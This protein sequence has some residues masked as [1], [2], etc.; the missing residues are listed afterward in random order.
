MAANYVVYL[1]PTA[2]ENSDIMEAIRIR[3]A[4]LGYNQLGWLVFSDSNREPIA[5]FTPGTVRYVLKEHLSGETIDVD[6]PEV[7]VN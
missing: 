4:D 2:T 5:C 1:V 3:D 6:A 7:V